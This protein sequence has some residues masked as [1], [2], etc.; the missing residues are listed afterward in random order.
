MGVGPATIGMN[1]AP[2]QE[3]ALIQRILAGE[4]ELFHE[5]IR[6]YERLVYVTILAMVRN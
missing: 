6:P 2:Q 1:R 3:A 4:S 5:L